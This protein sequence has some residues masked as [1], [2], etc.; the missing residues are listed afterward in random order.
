V[1]LIG[2]GGIFDDIGAALRQLPGS[3]SFPPGEA[4]MTAIGLTGNGNGRHIVYRAGKTPHKVAG[5]GMVEHIVELVEAKAAD[6]KA[7][8]EAEKLAAEQGRTAAYEQC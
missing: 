3:L 6:P 2:I 8:T 5:G 7:A 1:P 4:L